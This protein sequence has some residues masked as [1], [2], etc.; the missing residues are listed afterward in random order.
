M[1]N[2]KLTG[3]VLSEAGLKLEHKTTGGLATYATAKSKCMV[4]VAYVN[5]HQ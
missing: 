3:N 4:V 5:Q 1:D 2:Q